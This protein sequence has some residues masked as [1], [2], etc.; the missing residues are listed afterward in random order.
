LRR[1]ILLVDADEVRRRF[2]ARLGKRLAP[3]FASIDVHLAEGDDGTV[4]DARLRERQQIGV[5]ATDDVLA[6][7]ALGHVPQKTLP[8]KRGRRSARGGRAHPS[9][10]NGAGVSPPGLLL[11]GQHAATRRVGGR[12]VRVMEV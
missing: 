10:R 12:P 8:T 1:L 6:I 5:Y 11:L 9:H 3:R 7:A 2:L 4:I